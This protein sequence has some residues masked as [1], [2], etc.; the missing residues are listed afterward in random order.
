VITHTHYDHAGNAGAFPRARIHVQ[1]RELQYATGRYM[2]HARLRAPFDPAHVAT[3]VHAV[4]AERVVFHDGDWELAPG[5][6]VHLIGGHTPGLQVVRVRT[7]R[8]FVLLASDASHL[9]ANI[10]QNRPFPIVHDV[11]AMIE[12]Y[13][14]I[15]ALADSPQHII[16][17]HD[18]AVMARY[19]APSRELQGI[20]V[21]LDVAPV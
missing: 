5:I 21:R 11:G 10:E 12:G 15:R 14:R 13:A 2:A 7:A 6:T 18:P 20:C 16:P 3:L 9:Y 19:P 8:G 17:G 4:F 1:D